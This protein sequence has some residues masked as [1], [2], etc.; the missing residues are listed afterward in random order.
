MPEQEIT[1]V[2][3]EKLRRIRLQ[4]TLATERDAH[5]MVLD[6]VATVVVNWLK[7]YTKRRPHEIVQTN[8]YGRPTV[9]I[10][11]RAKKGFVQSPVVLL[12]L[13]RV[14]NHENKICGRVI[15]VCPRYEDDHPADHLLFSPLKPEDI[16]RV[17][18]FVEN[19]YISKRF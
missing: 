5:F 15:I 9:E 11:F 3:Q 13:D 19:Y 8:R 18:E 4:K 17:A 14:L 1:N 10:R 6:G 2:P 16:K 12:F 7:A